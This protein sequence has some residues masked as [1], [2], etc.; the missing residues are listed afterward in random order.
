MHVLKE[1]ILVIN[2][3][4]WPVYP[5]IGEALLR[6]CE[7]KARDSYV[8]V[9]LQD[10]A[11]IRSQLTKHNRGN[12]VNFYPCKAWSVSGSGITVRI[13]DA[14]FFMLWVFLILL[15]KRPTKV[16]V[17]TDPPV[18]VPFIVMVY[19]KIFSAQYIYHLQDIHPEAANVIIPMN[20]LVYNSLQW[21]DSLVMRRAKLLITITDEMALEIKKRSG[22]RI[23]IYV[24][25]NPAIEFDGVKLAEGKK[26]GFTF[27]GNAGRLQ[28]IP[29]VID[30][31]EKYCKKGGGLPFVFAGAGVHSESLRLLANKYNNV[32][33]K[34]LITATEAASLNCEYEWALLPI[35]DDVT[36]FSFPS[37]SSS[38]VYS[39]ACIA[40]IC[41]E[42]TSVAKWVKN[43]LLGRVVQADTTIL[44][45]FFSDV[46]SGFINANSFDHN[47][48][49]L[50]KKLSFDIFV[51][52]LALLVCDEG[53]T[54][55]K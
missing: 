20:K 31:I 47:R 45:Q 26:A 2:R 25:P 38:Y 41:G 48:G 28:R 9:V 50:K 8:G 36:R 30:A 27:C 1:K 3:S 24:L 15:M 33:Y 46:E 51:N 16:Y 39:G 11:N 21:F 23:P 7:I 14:I 43:N 22:T 13:L 42:S 37:K 35:E 4:F 10:H 5:V 12:G 54:S 19:C 52:S 53:A 18:L 29:L 44:C 17:S 32:E 40:A 55:E 49:D 6:F 34:G